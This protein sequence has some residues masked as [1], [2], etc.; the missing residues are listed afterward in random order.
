[1][2]VVR[3]K[4]ETLE[5]WSTDVGSVPDVETAV[6]VAEAVLLPVFGAETVKSQKPFRAEIDQDNWLV[7]GAVGAGS[8]QALFV[9]IAKVDCRI[10][11]ISR[12]S[13]ESDD[14]GARRYT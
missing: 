9:R 4:V 2:T 12:K 13:V 14:G 1:M 6:R 7:R 3:D 8:E 11:E 10:L 5:S